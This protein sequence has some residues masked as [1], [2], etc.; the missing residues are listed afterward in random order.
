MGHEGTLQ[1]RGGDQGDDGGDEDEEERGGAHHDGALLAA[2]LHVVV[3]DLPQH[4]GGRQV[5]QRLGAGG[6]A[7][8]GEK[9]H[10]LRGDEENRARKA[11]G[12]MS[13]RRWAFHSL[14]N[15]F[16]PLSPPFF[17]SP[18]TLLYLPSLCIS[19]TPLL[20]SLSS[21]SPHSLSRRTHAHLDVLAG[22]CPRA[23]RVLREGQRRVRHHAADHAQLRAQADERHHLRG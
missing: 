3:G 19:I 7:R 16:S 2:L 23:R 21:N 22:A 4:G 12:W 8:G 11:A 5:E 9:L 18:I 10:H 20:S 6:A 14:K 1:V 15:K 13:G 17:P